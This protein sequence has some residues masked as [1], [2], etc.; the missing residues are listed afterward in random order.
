[1]LS[2]HLVADSASGTEQHILTQV[3]E[4]LHEQFDISHATVQVEGDGFEH[5]EHDEVHA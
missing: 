3:T 1:V 5:D 4:L 2:T